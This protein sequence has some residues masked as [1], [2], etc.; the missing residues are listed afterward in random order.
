MQ[1]RVLVL[2]ELLTGWPRVSGVKPLRHRLKGAYRF[3]VGDWRVLVR[4]EGEVLR[5]FRID[6]RRDVYER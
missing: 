2:F 5:V 1:Q 4:A 6:H 3:R